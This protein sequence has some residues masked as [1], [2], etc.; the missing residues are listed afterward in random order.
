MSKKSKVKNTNIQVNLDDLV[1]EGKSLD[2]DKVNET[3]KMIVNNG[4]K[5]S[6]GNFEN[7]Q[8]DSKFSETITTE[9][10]DENT[11]IEGETIDTQDPTCDV[12]SEH[13]NKSDDAIE[14]TND[15]NENIDDV[16]AECTGKPEVT[17]EKQHKTANKDVPWYVARA[18]RGND[19]FNW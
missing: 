16:I 7:V 9:N 10:F 13:I 1:N 19:Y 15:I 3:Y 12:K 2:V 8:E 5:D 14:D 4:K 6:D 18:M 17:T 11:I